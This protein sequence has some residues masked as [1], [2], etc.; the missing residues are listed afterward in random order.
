MVGA[1]E[2]NGVACTLIKAKECFYA[3]SQG[4]LVCHSAR[5]ARVLGAFETV[6]ANPER[7]GHSHYC[8]LL[9]PFRGH[10][11]KV[12]RA[13]PNL[14]FTFGFRKDGGG[15]GS[16]CKCRQYGQCWQQRGLRYRVGGYIRFFSSRK[17]AELQLCR[18]QICTIDC[19][20]EHKPR[21]FHTCHSFSFGRYIVK[22][23]RTRKA[24]RWDQ[25]IGCCPFGQSIFPSG[26]LVYP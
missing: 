8:G 4:D 2:P 16:L 20:I 22:E 12:D 17:Q 11:G 15:L 24:G 21:G 1:T 25:H 19:G 14:S 10:C 7:A 26:K 23:K 9:Y 6:C 18:F 13:D 3:K 5:A